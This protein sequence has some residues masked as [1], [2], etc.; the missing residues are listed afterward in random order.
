MS[1]DTPKPGS[2]RETDVKQIDHNDSIRATYL[3][4]EDLRDCG[5][6]L[7]RGFGLGEAEARPEGEHEGGRQQDLPHDGSPIGSSFVCAAAGPWL[8]GPRR[9]TLVAPR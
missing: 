2:S 4:I 9:T 5:V 6:R 1:L 8:S 3:T 7:G